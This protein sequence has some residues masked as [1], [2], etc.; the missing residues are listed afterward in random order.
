MLLAAVS[1]LPLTTSVEQTQPIFLLAATDRVISSLS[2]GNATEVSKHDDLGAL[3]RD[4]CD[5]ARRA[6]VVVGNASE[7]SVVRARRPCDAVDALVEGGGG[8]PGAEARSGRCGGPACRSL[9]LFKVRAIAAGLEQAPGGAIYVDNDVALRA[10]AADALFALVGAVAAA[11][12]ALGLAPAP[13]CVPPGHALDDVPAAFCERNTGLIAFAD[14]GRSLGVVAAWRDELARNASF[15]RGGK[16][17]IRGRFNTS[18]PRA[19]VPE[20]SREMTARPKMSRHEWNMTERGASKVG[21]VPP[22]VFL[23]PGPST[24]TRCPCGARSTGAAATSTTSRRPCSAGAR[25]ASGRP[26]RRRT[27]RSSGTTTAPRASASRG[28]RPAATRPRAA[29]SGPN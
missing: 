22:K 10:G 21:N 20:K 15:D 2:P 26:A 16:R 8:A 18:V 12:R 4:I 14:V 13:W 23:C 9:R 19:I 25:A 11:G 27:G 24:T 28:G 6:V 7:A 1:C 3:L 5:A 17:V 29:A